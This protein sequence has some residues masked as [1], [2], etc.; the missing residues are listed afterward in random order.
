MTLQLTELTKTRLNAF[1]KKYPSLKFDDMI[2]KM[3]DNAQLIID[4]LDINNLNKSLTSKIFDKIDFIELQIGQI[5]DTITGQ[6]IN[7]MINFKN[8]FKTEIGMIINN[9]TIENIIPLLQ[10]YN[11]ELYNKTLNEFN[12]IIPK[13]N[14]SLS[15]NIST[16]LKELYESINRDTLHLTQ[17]SLNQN[18]LNDFISTIDNKFN[19]SIT[20]LQQNLNSNINFTESRLN[21]QINGIRELTI[22]NKETET[23]ILNN[24]TKHFGKLENSTIKGALSESMLNNV[25]TDLFETAE[26]IDVSKESHR[27]DF[28]MNRNNKPKILF[29]NKSHTENVPTHEVNKFTSDVLLENCSGIFISQKSGICLKGNFE[30]DIDKNNNVLVYLTKVNYNPDIIKIA[31]NIVDYLKNIIDKIYINCPTNS[32]NINKS[33]IES[34]NNEFVIFFEKKT[35]IINNINQLKKSIDVIIK[36]FDDITFPVIENLFIDKS[37]NVF[38]TKK[39]FI[40][41]CSNVFDTQKGLNHHKATC[42]TSL[43]YEYNLKQKQSITEI[44]E[45]NIVV[46]NILD[47]IKESDNDSNGTVSSI[48]SESCCNSTL[49]KTKK[50]TVKISDV[51]LVCELCNGQYKTF[52]SKSLTIHKNSCLKKNEY[53]K[54]ISSNIDKTK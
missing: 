22:I 38:S 49:K 54:I 52:N 25:L 16:F 51:E 35:N 42:N 24:I 39:K 4:N 48:N 11:E 50:Y 5:T 21:T 33:D 15:N 31:V 29:E 27:G 14:D 10:K 9:N 7:Q 19:N 12:T 46:E 1:Y 3:L 40:C 44:P 30:I 6:L 41:I 28:I 34:I 26:I 2:N 18:T 47:D 53:K 32:R 20:I 13:N 23:Q 17:Q 45:N 8:D 43:I 36:S 37:K